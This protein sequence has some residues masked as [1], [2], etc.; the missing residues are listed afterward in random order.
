[1]RLLFRELRSSSV[2]VVLNN[3]LLRLTR[4]ALELLRGLRLLEICI[5][6]DTANHWLGFAVPHIH[7]CCAAH[8]RLLFWL[9]GYLV[10]QKSVTSIRHL[11]QIR[12]SRIISPLNCLIG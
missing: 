12:Q 7:V 6:D 3:D 1:M 11:G 2:L 5:A 8:T 10:G 4:G 9:T